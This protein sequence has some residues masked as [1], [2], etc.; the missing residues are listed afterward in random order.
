[1]AGERI[2]VVDDDQGL[3]TLLKVR[4]E[5]AGYKA[6]VAEGAEQALSR[7]LDDP[8]DMAIIDLKLNGINGIT[9]LE[10][11]L[12]LHPHLP[13]II[14]TAHGT[15]ASAVEATKKGAYDYLTKPFD[16][17]DLLHRIEKAL[18]VRR[19]RGEVEQ[20]RT[21]V[22]ER[23]HPDNIVA[24][25]D[26]MQHVLRQVAQIAVTDSTVCL[27]GESGT[28]KELIAK[29]M[30]A[31]SRRARGPF[32]AINCGAIPEGLLE[33]ELFGH[34]KG[35]Y[36]GADQVH[37]GLLRQADGGTLFLDE[38]G[39]LPQ[40]LQ[41]KFLRV[42]QEHEFYPLGAGQPT[43]ADFRLIA[44]TN[45]DLWEAVCKG[46][47]REDLYYRIHV[48]PIVLPPLRERQEDIPL[49]AHHFLQRFVHAVR[50]GVKGFSSEAM[51]QL[52]VYDWP[53]NIRELAN[54]VERAVV[55]ATEDLITPDLI[56]LGR[57]PARPPKSALLLFKDARAA[58][59]RAYLVQ[60]LTATRGNV[61]RAA[62]LSGRHRA[63]FYKLLRKYNLDPA[64]FKDI[65]E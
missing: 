18:E 35:A 14:L 52:M 50:K 62:E 59:E 45:Q 17:K 43:R 13:V 16:P 39:E 1:M 46:R 51:Q 24:S 21:L 8:Y 22:R 7:E 42:L 2:L 3:L 65:P 40:A 9:L 20:L 27:Y 26:K 55:L 36:T 11:L 49:L 64:S 5:A 37:R 15:I 41:V 58:F 44:A 61:S 32:V 29:S 47:F 57:Q 25:S 63:E 23:Y 53:G 48:I 10:K 54:V 6:I 56:L 12:R 28:G 30:H 38:I 33:N 19:L 31:T 4:L 34:V 60:V